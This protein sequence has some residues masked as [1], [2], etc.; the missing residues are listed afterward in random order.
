MPWEDNQPSHDWMM[1]LGARERR[2]REGIKKMMQDSQTEKKSPNGPLDGGSAIAGDE[3]LNSGE[4]PVQACLCNHTPE[5]NVWS[6]EKCVMCDGYKTQAQAEATGMPLIYAWGQKKVESVEE[7]L[8]RRNAELKKENRD[9]QC[10][11]EFVS[12]QFKLARERIVMLENSLAGERRNQ[13]I[14][15][16]LSDAEDRDFVLTG[17][18][19]VVPTGDPEVNALGKMWEIVQNVPAIQYSRMIEWL[20]CRMRHRDGQ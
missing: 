17:P 9:L 12:G 7:Y 13:A 5:S 6:G 8:K 19:Y 16:A 20:N 11:E 2:M 4:E 15:D 3:L 1:F 10:R 18:M 14:R